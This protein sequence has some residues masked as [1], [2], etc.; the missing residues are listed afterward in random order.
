MKFVVTATEHEVAIFI[1]S[2]D[3]FEEAL[4]I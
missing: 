3:G 2:V 1:I 4:R